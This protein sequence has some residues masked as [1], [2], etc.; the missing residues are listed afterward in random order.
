MSQSSQSKVGQRS[1][2]QL[3]CIARGDRYPSHPPNVAT[4]LRWCWQMSRSSPSPTC[5]PIGASHAAAYFHPL[6]GPCDFKPL[7][8]SDTPTI[9]LPFGHSF[10]KRYPHLLSEPL[11]L[12]PPLLFKGVGGGKLNC[13]GPLNPKREYAGWVG[14]MQAARECV[15]YK[16]DS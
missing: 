14:G 3:P 12:Q 10:A 11:W 13:L 1:L 6:R 2:H 9:C 5:I 15:Q 7:S 4:M 16:G 8:R